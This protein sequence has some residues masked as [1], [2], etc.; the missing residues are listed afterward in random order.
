MVF[1]V[2]AAQKGIVRSTPEPSPR[3]AADTAVAKA[4]VGYQVTVFDDANRVMMICAP[5]KKFRGG[6][7]A[8]RGF[9][10]ARCRVVDPSFK[11]RLKTR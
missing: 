6:K 11:R 1:K 9:K 10:T 5:G 4:S 3:R 7:L 2:H 8:A